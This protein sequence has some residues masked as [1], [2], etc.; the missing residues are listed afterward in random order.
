MKV[1]IVFGGV[2]FEHEISI[3]SSIAMK[4]VLKDELIY[5]FLDSSRDMY[6][7]PTDIIKSKLFSSGDYKKFE[8]VYFQKG[9]FYK[10]GGLFSKD[11]TIDFDVVLN[12]SHGGD[13]EDGILSSVLDFYS[14]P[15]IAP[16]TEACVISSNK[17]LTKG[18]AS[19]VGVNTLDYKYYTKGDKV[20]VESFP[21]ILKPVKLGSSIGVS[22][23]KSQ[24]E[25]EYALD[26]A[27]EFDNAVIIEPFISGVK[28][29]N[30]A[31]TKVNGEFK[32]SIS[33]C[34][35]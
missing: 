6:Y 9:G 20:A 21:V 10:K 33:F 27:Y 26:V 23:V 7:I 25:L 28:E 3:V 12:L 35:S 24:E 32:L 13:G 16:R 2:S 14:I 29:Y 5:L 30:L 19:S 34:S 11:K 22:I 15:F 31:G 4:D 18:Y 8:K 17:F 1:A